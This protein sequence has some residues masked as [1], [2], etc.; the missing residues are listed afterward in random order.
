[1]RFESD[2]DDVVQMAGLMTEAN[3]S[4]TSD[5]GKSTSLTNLPDSR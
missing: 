1:M 2:S 4:I 3:P 5:A